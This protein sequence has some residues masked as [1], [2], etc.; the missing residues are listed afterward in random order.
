[1][2]NR[3]HFLW[4]AGAAGAAAPVAVGL[5]LARPGPIAGQ[6]APGDQ[7]TFRAITAMPKQ[8]LPAFASQV[9][10]GHLNPGTHSG[11]ITQTVFAGAPSAMSEIALPGLS[12]SVRV[13]DIRQV[14]DLMQVTGVVD[15]RSQLRPG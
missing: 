14:G 4:L 13:T 9:L 7:F 12:R 1:M 6:P 15:D 3:R 2:L 11:M 5:D 10:T 8:P